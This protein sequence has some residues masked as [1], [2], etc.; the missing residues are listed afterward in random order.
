VQGRRHLRDH[1]EADEGGQN[2][3]G[4]FGNQIHAGCSLLVARATSY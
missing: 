4:D 1:L 2:E 3:D